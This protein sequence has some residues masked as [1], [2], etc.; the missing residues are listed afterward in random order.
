MPHKTAY[1]ERDSRGRER[2][3]IPR[4]SHSHG[5]THSHGR[6]S[7]RELLNESEEREAALGVELAAVQNRLSMAERDKW[8]NRTLTEQH[9]RLLHDHHQ[10][11]N[12]HAQLDAQVRE[13]RRIEDVLADEE[14]KSERLHQ[15]V[16]KL[17][18][19]IDDLKEKNRVLKRT[20]GDYEVWRLRYDEKAVEADVLRLQLTERDEQIRRADLRIQEKNSTISLLKDYLRQ[21]GFRVDG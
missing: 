2:L 20:S 12:L 18:E 1:I 16:Q 11:H 8:E 9:Q 21:H 13:V 3:V 17:E 4:R 7:D 14:Y 5:R 19:K 15:R 10:C 6:K